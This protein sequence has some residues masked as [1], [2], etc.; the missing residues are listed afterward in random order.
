KFLHKQFD[1]EI[2]NMLFQSSF[3]MVYQFLQIDDPKL[4]KKALKMGLNTAH[5]FQN[6]LYEIKF[7][8][9]LTLLYLAEGKIKKSSNLIERLTELTEKSE[10]SFPILTIV[11]DIYGDFH[12]YGINKKE[13]QYQ[14]FRELWN[15]I[16]NAIPIF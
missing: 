10:I 9:A 15:Y 11:R 1:L 14:A 3:F 4:T 5:K 16:Q 7:A 13:L 12:E 8:I 6:T 2:H